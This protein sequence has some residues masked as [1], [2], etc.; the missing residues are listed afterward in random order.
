MN[1]YRMRRIKGP[2]LE[3]YGDLTEVDF[4]YVYFCIRVCFMWGWVWESGRGCAWHNTSMLNVIK[5]LKELTEV[6]TT[7]KG[8]HNISIPYHDT[9][10][11]QDSFQHFT[12][13]HLNQGSN[14]SQ[15]NVWYSHRLIKISVT[16]CLFSSILQ[17]VCINISLT[18]SYHS[19]RPYHCLFRAMSENVNTF[20]THRAPHFWLMETV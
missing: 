8:I 14:T 13:L 4:C 2:S 12:R 19:S 7:G 18:I 17:A 9:L 10:F 3:A 6:N 1:S 5:C 16:F 15:C 20:H 11:R